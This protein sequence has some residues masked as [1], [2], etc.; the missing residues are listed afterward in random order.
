M[1]ENLIYVIKNNT[2]CSKSFMTLFSA[3]FKFPFFFMH[4][5]NYNIMVIDS[6]FQLHAVRKSGDTEDFKGT[7][8]A[9][10]SAQD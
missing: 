10:R 6:S 9:M 3:K 1:Y 2:G 7:L 5:F 4:Y 8:C